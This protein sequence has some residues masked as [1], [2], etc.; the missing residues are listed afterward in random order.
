MRNIAY[1]AMDVHARHCTLGEM[2]PSSVGN[3]LR[4]L[5]TMKGWS[6]GRTDPSP[7]NR[8]ALAALLQPLADGRKRFA[9]DRQ[10][11]RLVALAQYGDQATGQVE[12]G[13]IQL[14]QFRESEAG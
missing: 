2:S 7:Q 8:T 6:S 5:V 3:P 4:N 10:C 13:D 1:L 11:A 14:N 12:V 9:A